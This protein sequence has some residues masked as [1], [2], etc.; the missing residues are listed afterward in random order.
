VKLH[1]ENAIFLLDDFEGTEK[2]VTN[3][4]KL[5][6]VFK[7]N[8]LLAYPPSDSFLRSNGFLDSSTTA[9]LIPLSKLHFVNQG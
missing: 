8:F 6:N 2:G 3:A 7:N 4:F 5:L 1:A 9:V